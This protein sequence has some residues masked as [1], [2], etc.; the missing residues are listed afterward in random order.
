MPKSI[1]TMQT[2]IFH[3]VRWQTLIIHR[4]SLYYFITLCH[5]NL[6]QDS[7]TLKMEEMCSSAMLVTINNTTRGLV[8]SDERNLHFHFE[9]RTVYQTY[10]CAE[11]SGHDRV[12]FHILGDR[13][14]RSSGYRPASYSRGPGFGSLSRNWLSWCSLIPPLKC[15]DSTKKKRPR[16]HPL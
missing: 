1:I 3:T 16:T 7:S 4:W 10:L 6:F 12:T 8:H 14:L 2:N 5:R 15:W 9:Y 13:T 11:P